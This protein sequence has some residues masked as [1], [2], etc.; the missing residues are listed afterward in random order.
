MTSRRTVLALPVAFGLALAAP[1]ALAAAGS[2][3][4]APSTAAASS[5]ATL[6]SGYPTL[7]GV[8]YARH[9]GYDRAVFDFTGGTPGWRAQYGPLYEQGRGNRISLAGNASLSIVFSVARAHDDAGRATYDLNR[10]L[11]PRLPTLRQIRFGGDF[12]GYV[13]VGLGL[14]DRVDYRIFRLANPARV[15]VDV[16]HQPSQP[17]RTATVHRAGTA[18]E[19]IVDR[20]RAGRH[21][22]Y[23]RVVFDVRGAA[24]PTLTVG[25]A[26]SSSA[27]LVSFTALGSATVSPHATY[28]GPSPLT[29]GL[30]A[31]R[32][33]TRTFV[34]A[35]TLTFRIATAHR[36][37]LRVLTLGSPTRIAVDVA[38]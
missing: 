4:P 24:Q 21:P 22:G 35:G 33:V 1:A 23:D 16:A 38:H 29:V 32:S 10:T 37:G 12:E 28:A 25:Y 18:V 17:F 7:V 36:H 15:V 3:T 5:A 27:L 26:G 20:V 2:A 14:A 34:G 6:P 30:P 8:R 9:A 19:V 13:G 31:V 11:D